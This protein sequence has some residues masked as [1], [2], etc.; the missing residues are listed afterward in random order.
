[1][2]QNGPDR[3]S[4]NRGIILKDGQNQRTCPEIRTERRER[5][6][7]KNKKKM[8]SSLRLLIRVLMNSMFF[9]QGVEL[10]TA[11]TGSLTGLGDIAVTHRH[12]M[13]EIL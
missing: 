1:M 7:E 3:F 11:D 9:D 4:E 6:V 10:G 12:Q 8:G 13:P 2:L 5:S